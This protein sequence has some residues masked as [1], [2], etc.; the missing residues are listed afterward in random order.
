MTKEREHVRR[1]AVKVT[2]VLKR[3]TNDLLSHLSLVVEDA[4]IPQHVD[5]S[6]GA[7]II[8]MTEAAVVCESDSTVLGLDNTQSDSANEC[9]HILQHFILGLSSRNRNMIACK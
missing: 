6:F 4:L 2:D 9:R 1:V 5:K 8:G 7:S 3:L